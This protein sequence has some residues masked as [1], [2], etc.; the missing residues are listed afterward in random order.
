MIAALDYFL[1]HLK[2]WN[3]SFAYSIK[4][5]DEY[6]SEQ[7]IDQLDRLIEGEMHGA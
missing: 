3:Y 2:H 4:L 1:D 7:I 6:A 5:V